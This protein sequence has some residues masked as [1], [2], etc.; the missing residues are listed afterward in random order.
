MGARG[1]KN[2]WRSIDFSYFS[3]LLTMTGGEL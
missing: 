1:S 3:F 2:G